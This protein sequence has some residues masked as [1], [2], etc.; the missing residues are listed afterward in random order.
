MQRKC[1]LLVFITQVY[2]DARSRERKKKGGGF[3]VGGGSILMDF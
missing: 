1:I 2:H 3:F